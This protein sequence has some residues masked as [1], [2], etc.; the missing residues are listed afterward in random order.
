MGISIDLERASLILEECYTIALEWH[1]RRVPAFDQTITDIVDI[2]ISSNTRS[3]RETAVGCGIARIYD[4]SIDITHPYMAQSETAYNGRTLDERVVN[5]FLQRNLMPCSKGP[6]LAT[7]RRNVAFV[8]ETIV[9]LR[10]A[11]GYKAFLSYIDALRSGSAADSVVLLSYLLYRFILLREQSDIPIARIARLSLEQL[12]ILINRFLAVQS[13]GLIPVLVVTATLDAIKCG[14]DLPWIITCQG[15]NESDAATGASADVTVKVGDDILL[16]IEVTERI[17]GRDRVIATFNSK[18]APNGLRD[19][20]F[21]YTAALPADDARA[22]AR[23]YFAQGHEVNFLQIADWSINI[24]LSFGAQLRE[25]FIISL[26]NKLSDRTV[27]ATVKLA[28]NNI[29]SDLLT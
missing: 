20:L 12:T 10:D 25:S 3:Y 22:A 6:F 16:A 15:I 13:G 9:G 24:L 19:Y 11:A 23:S 18:I 1:A 17:I 2:L 5:P 29:I 14:Y 28:W 8:P 7:F 4:P 21:A 27:P 26:T